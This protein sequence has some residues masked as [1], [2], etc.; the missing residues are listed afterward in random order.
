[1]SKDI[2]VLIREGKKRKLG[3]PEEVGRCGEGEKACAEIT[4][5]GNIQSFSGNTN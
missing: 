4:V 1:M 3:D 2:F 5:G